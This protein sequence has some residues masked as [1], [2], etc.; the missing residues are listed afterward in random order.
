[1]YIHVRIMLT[2]PIADPYIRLPRNT[3]PHNDKARNS[4]FITRGLHRQFPNHVL[5]PPPAPSHTRERP[6][7]PSLRDNPKTMG[8]GRGDL[9]AHASRRRQ[10]TGWRTLASPQSSSSVQISYSCA[11]SYSLLVV[12]IRYIRIE[13]NSGWTLPALESVRHGLDLYVLAFP[14]LVFRVGIAHFFSFSFAVGVVSFLI[15]QG[16][17]IDPMQSSLLESK[18]CVQILHWFIVLL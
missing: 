7:S 16:S 11:V 15:P 18:F 13:Y 10:S 14:C 9:H 6:R 17:L 8:L 1:M 12:S 4:S 3:K 5:A 2:H